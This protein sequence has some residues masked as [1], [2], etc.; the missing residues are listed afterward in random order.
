MNAVTRTTP[1]RIRSIRIWCEHLLSFT[2]ERPADYR[3]KAGQFARLGLQSTHGEAGPDGIVWRA[4]SMASGPFDESLEFY[5]IVV[6][7]GAFTSALAQCQVGDWVYLDRQAYGYLTCDRFP[8]GGDLW[9]LSSG[10]GLAPFLSMLNDPETWSQFDHLVLVHSVRTSQ[11]LAYR[12]WIEWLSA[13][14]IWG[15]EAHRLSYQPVVTR[16]PSEFPS[17]R[18]PALIETGELQ[19]LLTRPTSLEVSRWMICGNPSMVQ[20]CKE[21]LQKQGFMTDR[22]SRP[23]QIATENYW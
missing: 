8:M 17:R 3:F 7:G 2:L 5:S 19:A 6:P 10:T 18:I 13:H 11:E 4:Y 9:M 16:S 12:E 23:G 21:T 14:P 1:V 15:A 22:P 20:D